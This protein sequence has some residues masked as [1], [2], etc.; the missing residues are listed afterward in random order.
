VENVLVAP[1]IAVIS[2]V[3]S[4]GNVPLA[5][6]LWKGGISFGGVIAFIF[7]DLIAFPL[8][9]IYRRYYGTRLS[10]RMLAVFWATMSTAGLITEVLFRGAGLVPRSR[11]VNVAPA[12]FSWNY[13]TY[14][15]IVFLCLFAALVWIYRN[16]AKWGAGSGSAQDPACHM[17]V[18]IAHAPAV[19]LVDG[20]PLYF[21]S[22]RCAHH[23]E[24]GRRQI[25]A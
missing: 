6:A 8:L 16:R 5:A 22:D 23:F 10:L 7:A 13:T 2:F 19:R 3:C 25:G 15:N 18:E 14:L 11:P 21:C 20:K 24:A 9:M 4:I 1:F 12:H 17:V